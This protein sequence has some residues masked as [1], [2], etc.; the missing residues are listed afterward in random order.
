MADLTGD[1]DKVPETNTKPD[2]LFTLLGSTVPG[3]TVPALSAH[4]SSAPAVEKSMRWCSGN[5]AREE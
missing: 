5:E 2:P 4:G 1:T 3:T